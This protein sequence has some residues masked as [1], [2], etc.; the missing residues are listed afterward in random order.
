VA[1]LTLKAIGYT[2]AQISDATG[3]VPRTAQGIYSR[4][5]KR[6]FD[7]AKRPLNIRAA[8]V[9]TTFPGHKKEPP[10]TSNKTQCGDK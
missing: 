8:H 2:W 9:T 7:V 1:V 3:V 4:A 10:E 6:G 5:S